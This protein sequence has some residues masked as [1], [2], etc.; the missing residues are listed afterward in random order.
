MAIGAEGPSLPGRIELTWE[1]EPRVEFEVQM[2]L[3]VNDTIVTDELIAHGFDLVLSDGRLV[4]GNANRWDYEE[5]TVTM[6]GEVS[7]VAFGA[8]AVRRMRCHVVNFPLVN[9]PRF[10]EMR[11]GGWALRL[12]D[13][14]SGDWDEKGYFVTGRLT[15][16]REDGCEFDPQD[17]QAIFDAFD[18]F[19]TLSQGS[20]ASHA[21]SV[22]TAP[23]G[24]IVWE[25]WAVNRCDRHATG[26][27]WAT[28]Y[29]ESVEALG[30]LWP[31]FL[32]KWQDPEWQPTMRT[33]VTMLAEATA[34]TDGEAALLMIDVVLELLSW[35]VVVT[36]GGMVTPEGHDRLQGGDR[37]RL[38]LAVA[39][40]DRRIPANL[41]ELSAAASRLRWVDGPHAITQLRDAVVHPRKRSILRDVPPE[42]ISE[43]QLLARDYAHGAIAHLLGALG[44]KS[45]G[46]RWLAPD[47]VIAALKAPAGGLATAG[48]L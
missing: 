25:R 32:R 24:R 42:A 40:V 27:G 30:S 3:G 26:D 11:G 47:Q 43:A 38:L 6:R 12:E 36:D 41:K 23:N 1:P 7:P 35:A 28:Q 29:E 48:T 21:L 16:A 9:R 10:T 39:Q 37:L 20:W 22:G 15:L 13:R 4:V 5:A 31:G 44:W 33:L 17:G 2:E 14:G 34:H 45:W 19:A 18:F 46:E 8:S